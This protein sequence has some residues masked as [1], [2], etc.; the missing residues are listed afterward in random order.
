MENPA[1][2]WA[3]LVV[4]LAWK[5]RVVCQTEWIFSLPPKK[6]CWTDASPLSRTSRRQKCVVNTI[7]VLSCAK[8]S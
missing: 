5:V 4:V 7:E 2:A 6:C 3:W 1:G 8:F